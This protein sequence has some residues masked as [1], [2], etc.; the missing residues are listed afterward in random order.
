MPRRGLRRVRRDCAALLAGLELPPHTDLA[1]LCAH[2]ARARGRPL[3]V[4]PVAMLASQ[5][6]GIWVA[7]GD[8]DWIFFDEAAPAAHQ[9]H[10][11]L[12][13]IGHMICCHRGGG[14]LDADTAAVFFPD[15]DPALVRDMLGR[16]TYSDEQEQQA[17]VLAYLLGEVLRG[18]PPPGDDV[19]ARIAGSL[20]H[21]TH[22]EA[23]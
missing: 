12:H 23:V 19:A 4:V 13:E 1:G 21:S 22:P 3:H 15:I 16:T 17:E 2:L 10:I 18:A 7:T 5:P 20:N 14:H 9:E 8:A 11:I 6:C